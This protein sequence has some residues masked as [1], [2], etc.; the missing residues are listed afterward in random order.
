MIAS[1]QTISH[2]FAHAIGEKDAQ[3]VS[4]H[5][6]AHRRFHANASCAAGEDQI[7][8]TESTESLMQVCLVETTKARFIEHD[9]SVVRLQFRYDFRVPG[10]ANQYAAR[11]S[12]GR[13]GA[14][15]NTDP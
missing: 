12:I 2:R 9:V 10:V 11:R 15:A 7:L 3:I 4:E 1:G 8:D 13:C 6:V 5:C 14:L